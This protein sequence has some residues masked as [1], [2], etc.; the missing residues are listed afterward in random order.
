MVN[1]I[2]FTAAELLAIEQV[3]EPAESDNPETQA[4]IESAFLKVGLALERPWAL[5]QEQETIKSVAERLS[6]KLK[7]VHLKIESMSLSEW[8]AWVDDL[9]SDERLEFLSKY[10]SKT[11][12]YH[13]ARVRPPTYRK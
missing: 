7:E 3:L 12:F 8:E 4:A 1:R 5:K 6:L 9:D 11:A 10:H 13:V 2:E